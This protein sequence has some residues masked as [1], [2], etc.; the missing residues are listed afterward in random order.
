MSETISVADLCRK[1]DLKPARFYYWKDQLLNSAPEIF[2]NRGRK[3]DE[4]C[5]RAE[6]YKEIARLK[7]TIADV[8]TKNLEIKKP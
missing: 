5:I 7:A 6:K 3:V 2:E 8:E 4:D 1:Y